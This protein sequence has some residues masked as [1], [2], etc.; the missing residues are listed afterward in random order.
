MK[1]L[2]WLSEERILPGIAHVT[3]GQEFLCDDDAA[4]SFVDQK[5]AEYVAQTEKRSVPK[6]QKE[7]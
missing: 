2:R 6:S 5:L 3:T 7:V 4:R 1:R